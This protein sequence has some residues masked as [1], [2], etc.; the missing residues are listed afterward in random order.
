MLFPPGACPGAWG[1]LWGALLGRLQTA[2]GLLQV[3]AA[4]QLRPL[5]L[6]LG[7]LQPGLQPF[8]DHVVP[9]SQLILLGARLGQQ[10]L[11]PGQLILQGR[12]LFRP[13]ARGSQG[14]PQPCR[15]SSRVSLWP[16]QPPVWRPIH[17]GP[18]APGAEERTLLSS[19]WARAHSPLSRVQPKPAPPWAC[20]GGLDA[21]HPHPCW[22]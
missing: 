14:L 11:Q 8:A 18:G 5:Q 22:A 13:G 9:A 4:L 1:S 3:H 10:A 2:Q 20:G 12:V 19:G 16:G 6:G 15:R 17:P 7:G 21:G